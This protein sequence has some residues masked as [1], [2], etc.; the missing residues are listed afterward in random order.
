[1]QPRERALVLLDPP[2]ALDVGRGAH[3]QRALEHALGHGGLGAKQCDVDVACGVGGEPWLERRLLGWGLAEITLSVPSGGK[4][5]RTSP[6]TAVHPREDCERGDEYG[7]VRDWNCERRR[8][9]VLWAR[10][11]GWRVTSTSAQAQPKA[12]I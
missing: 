7:D 2:D 5:G 11:L 4:V 6:P 3:E 12:D 8:H 1:M 10:S 9:G